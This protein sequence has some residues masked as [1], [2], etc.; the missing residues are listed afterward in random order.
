MAVLKRIRCSSRKY[1]GLI[2]LA[3]FIK[4]N[5]ISRR[6]ITNICNEGLRF[7]RVGY[8]RQY[9]MEII[10]KRYVKPFLKCVPDITFIIIV[11]TLS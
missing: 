9:F 7:V 8:F 2:K 1:V 10:T 4:T 6:I 5:I 3:Y 11:G